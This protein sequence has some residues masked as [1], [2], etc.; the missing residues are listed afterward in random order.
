[1]DGRARWM[2]RRTQINIGM[3]ATRGERVPAHMT[4]LLLLSPVQVGLEACDNS[5]PRLL[6][7]LDGVQWLQLRHFQKF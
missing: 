7:G 3:E 2:R 4:P 1:M 5:Q 6:K